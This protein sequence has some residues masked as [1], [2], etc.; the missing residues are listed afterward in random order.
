[1]S[2]ARVQR[3]YKNNDKKV[4]WWRQG[5]HQ[6]ES[7][8]TV[9]E[10]L[11]L[12]FPSRS[13][14]RGILRVQSTCFIYC[15]LWFDCFN[16]F[17]KLF[18]IWMGWLKGGGGAVISCYCKLLTAKIEQA[19]DDVGG[20]EWKMCKFFLH[21]IFIRFRD[22]LGGR[23]GAFAVVKVVVVL[24]SWTWASSCHEVAVW[25]Y[26]V[27]GGASFYRYLMIKLAQQLSGEL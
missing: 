19:D 3:N 21:A 20:A 18:E 12:I 26:F 22:W 23:G 27:T 11:K 8:S 25:R 6:Q 13:A 10:T 9:K 4:S 2:R 5:F 7:L 1:M 15:S 17:V 24:Q 14:M 16:A